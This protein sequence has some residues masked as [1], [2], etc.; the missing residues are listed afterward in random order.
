MAT[1]RQRHHEQPRAPQATS[2]RIDDH[3]AEPEVHL[4]FLAGADF[5]PDCRLRCRR[6]VATQEAFHRR[7]TAI[8]AVLVDQELPDRL[9]LD[10]LL[11]QGRVPMR[12]F[13]RPDAQ[14]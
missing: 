10:A 8:E 1:K 14:R 11:V 13:H 6:C 5:H 2:R 9:A 7:V 12:K 4:R 3:A